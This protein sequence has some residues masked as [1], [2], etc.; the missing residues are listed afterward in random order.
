MAARGEKPM[1]ID[2]LQAALPAVAIALLAMTAG[3][4]LA[5]AARHR[6]RLLP[7][8]AA[9]EAQYSRNSHGEADPGRKIAPAT[10]T[11]RPQR[12]PG[13]EVESSP[14]PATLAP[15]WRDRDRFAGRSGRLTSWLAV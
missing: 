8:L 12:L 9:Q 6:A 4:S 1:A 3:Q 14:P 13:R 10:I 15:T 7:A 2:R 5:A 11:R